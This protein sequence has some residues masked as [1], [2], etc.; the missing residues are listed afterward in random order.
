M[1]P[2][3]DKSNA[4]LL[5]TA[6]KTSSY[7]SL[8]FVDD[9]GTPVQLVNNIKLLGITLVTILQC[10]S[11]DH[12]K[13]VSQSCFYHIRAFR[14]IRAVLDKTTAADLATALVSSRLDYTNSVLYARCGGAYLL[15]YLIASPTPNT[16]ALNSLQ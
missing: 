7:S 16:W 13:R 1:A 8:T 15:T 4:I 9:A 2:N 14:H 3:P 6:Q 12:T 10:G 5:G 11:W